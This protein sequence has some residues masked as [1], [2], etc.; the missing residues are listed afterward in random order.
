MEKALQKLRDEVSA[1]QYEEQGK[2]EEEKKKALEKLSQQVGHGGN[3][4][5]RFFLYQSIGGIRC[6]LIVFK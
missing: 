1:L 3:G 4:V 5:Y 6:A 2:L